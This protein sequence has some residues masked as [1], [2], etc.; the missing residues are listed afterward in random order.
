MT[1]WEI[2]GTKNYQKSEENYH[3]HVC[4]HGYNSLKAFLK[5][6]SFLV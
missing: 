3:A 4:L 1:E 5:L 2:F 6:V